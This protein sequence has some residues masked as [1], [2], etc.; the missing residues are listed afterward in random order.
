M[1]LTV[2]L[3]VLSTLCLGGI[4]DPLD[5]SNAA[6]NAMVTWF[7]V[8]APIGHLLLIRQ[9]ADTC[10]VRFTTFHRGHDSKPSTPFNSGE[11]SFSAEYDWFYPKKSAAGSHQRT[12]DTGHRQLSR[13][14]SSGIGRLAFQRGDQEV[15]CGNFRLAWYYPARVGFN[16]SDSAKDIGVELAPTRWNTIE[17]VDFDDPALRWYRQDESRKPTLIPMDQLP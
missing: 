12:Y 11:E 13:G 5:D 15:Q 14:S 6:N 7:D 2:A 9:G 17:Q 4:V 16:S 10:V 3:M 8:S 1:A